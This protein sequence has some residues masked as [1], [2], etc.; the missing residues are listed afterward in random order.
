MSTYIPTNVS[1]NG[2][3]NDD[4][5]WGDD[6]KNIMMVVVIVMMLTISKLLLFALDYIMFISFFASCDRAQLMY[7][8]MHELGRS[9]MYIIVGC[10]MQ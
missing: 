6:E 7:T 4:G 10:I 9:D 1:S 2:C 5:D 3:G 8:F